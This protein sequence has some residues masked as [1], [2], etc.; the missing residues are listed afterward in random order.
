MRNKPDAFLSLFFLILSLCFGIASLTYEGIRMVFLPAILSGTIFILSAIQLVRDL[1]SKKNSKA[2]VTSQPDAP[3]EETI[4]TQMEMDLGGNLKGELFGFVWLLGLVLFVLF[5]GFH[6]SI[7]VFMLIYLRVH[8]AS[9]I[10]TISLAVIM[11]AFVYFVFVR[12]FEVEL[13]NGL[14]IG[15]FLG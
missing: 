6:I 15:P 10:S 5:F 7:P 12:L 11:E 9:W 2:P 14:I 4:G 13:Y 8:N 1:S 3:D